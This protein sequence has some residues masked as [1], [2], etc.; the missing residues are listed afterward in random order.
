MIGCVTDTAL[1]RFV[2]GESDAAERAAI[3][4]HLGTCA[5]CTASVE[6]L[7]DIVA[8]L[9]R[10]PEPPALDLAPLVLQRAALP[11]PR[12]RVRVLR[13][14]TMA[15]AA[16]AGLVLGVGLDRRIGPGAPATGRE[17]AGFQAR[18]GGA[19]SPDKWVAI[20][21]YVVGG[22]G[23][24]RALVEGEAVACDERLLFAY[25]N[26]GPNPY[27]YLMIVAAGD[28]AAP[29]WLFP[30]GRSALETSIAIE[31]GAGRELHEEIAPGS[32]DGPRLAPSSRT[33]WGIFS[34]EPLRVADVR[35]QL[36]A[37][38]PRLAIAA[39]G[40]HRV[41]LRLVEGRDVH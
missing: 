26:G 21:P 13:S 10:D 34:R 7:R 27:R 23:R 17:E 24:T 33:L 6:D 15:L 25:D 9:G 39:T 2:D 30:E 12:S 16:A 28:G 36:S 4:R 19:E 20:H 14:L 35:A 38:A 37:G 32:C 8:A 11:Q 41:S 40:Q 18:G 3:T 29:L 5:R 1:A 31:P 22:D